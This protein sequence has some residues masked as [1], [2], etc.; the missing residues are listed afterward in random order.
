[1]SSASGTATLPR[2]HRNPISG[3]LL[4][5]DRETRY[6]DPFSSSSR[7][8]LLNHYPPPSFPTAAQSSLHPLPL[9]H[10]SSHHRKVVLDTRDY[11]STRREATDILYRYGGLGSGAAGPP[12]VMT[13]TLDRSGSSSGSGH[14]TSRQQQQQSNSTSQQQVNSQAGTGQQSSHGRQQSDQQSQRER[15]QSAINAALCRCGSGG[16]P[17]T[18]LASQV[19]QHYHPSSPPI[20]SAGLAVERGV[21]FGHLFG[22]PGGGGGGGQGLPGV[23]FGHQ[24]SFRGVQ[25]LPSTPNACRRPLSP[26]P[27]HNFRQPQAFDLTTSTG[28]IPPLP[29]PPSLVTGATGTTTT[30]GALNSSYGFN[31]IGHPPLGPPPPHPALIGHPSLTH[32]QSAPGHTGFPLTRGSADHF[33]FGEPS[34][35]QVSESAILAGDLSGEGGGGQGGPLGDTGQLGPLARLRALQQFNQ[36]QARSLRYRSS[37][38]QPLMKLSTLVIVVLALII[39][40]FIVL[41][42]LF[43]YIMWSFSSSYIPH[44]R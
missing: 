3:D 32:Q 42:P 29:P 38:S 35:G 10:P 27:Q 28:P 21:Q 6:I 33:I 12:P 2:I 22:P 40:G 24:S 41:S 9:P 43:H 13:S 14:R 7:T 36:Q 30:R 37:S 4:D 19:H 8:R 25:S 31:D 1:M 18:S 16:L 15:E 17:V 44:H 5:L 20:T 34:A 23:T 26:H 11:E 39:I